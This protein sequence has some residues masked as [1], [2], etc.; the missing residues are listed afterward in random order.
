LILE[1]LGIELHVIA[2]SVTR[3]KSLPVSS[4]LGLVDDSNSE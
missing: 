1:F 3:R 4:V 2:V